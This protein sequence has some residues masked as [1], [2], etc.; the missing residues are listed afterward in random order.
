MRPGSPRD[1]LDKAVL[2]IA[3][4]AGTCGVIALKHFG[5]GPVAAA[6]LAVGVLIAYV[7]FTSISGRTQIEPE[8]IG[9]NCY[10]LGFLFT[11]TSLAYT[12]Y[13]ISGNADQASALREI[14]SGF[15]VALLST[16]VGV[17][18]RVLM[19]Q[20]RADIVGRDREARA[21]LHQ[22]AREFRTALGASVATIKAFTT[23]SIQLAA[24]QSHKIARL[25]DELMESHRTRLQTD[26]ETYARTLGAAFEKAGANI[27]RD[28]GK[29]VDTSA[30]TTQGEIRRSLEV[31]AAGV[32]RFAA[33]QGSALQAAAERDI[34]AIAASERMAAAAAQLTIA[35]AAMAQ[36]VRSSGERLTS[37]IAASGKN[38][39]ATSSGFASRLAASI[40]D[41]ERTAQQAR[42]ALSIDGHG[43][44]LAPALVALADAAMAM[45][46]TADRI[47]TEMERLAKA[48][49]PEQGA[50]GAHSSGTAT[51]VSEPRRKWH[52]IGI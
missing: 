13:Q 16:I 27:V 35:L 32:S 17:F 20:M 25:T 2:V 14:I 7:V 8:S 34:S 29:T 21:E 12:L 46:E 36:N 22:A 9:D 1:V 31:L 26:Q 41:I 33:E 39:E 37:E 49:P 50:L 23:E 6:S 11:L 18:L 42:A 3:F 48:L 28:V 40:L 47:Q 24:E 51:S 44:P 4:L 15:G 19:M 43:A 52:G 5:A 38:L 45:K 10:Y 30:H